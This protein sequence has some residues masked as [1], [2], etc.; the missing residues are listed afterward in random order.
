[1]HHVIA[2]AS[3]GELIAAMPAGQLIAAAAPAG[4]LTPGAVAW[5]AVGA[6]GAILLLYL[7]EL[8]A[9]LALQRTIAL[10]ISAEV[11]AVLSVVE[12]RGYAGNFREQIAKGERGEEMYL[13]PLAISRDYFPVT[14]K[15][16]EKIGTLPRHLAHA[17]VTYYVWAN[18]FIEDATMD[19]GNGGRF[20]AADLV[21]VKDALRVLEKAEAAGE[22]VIGLVR[23]YY[24]TD[25][26]AWKRVQAGMRRARSEL[27]A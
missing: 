9:R 1:M 17:V 3:A 6:L 14:G 8:I 20:P 25:A 18:A 19:R 7:K 27:I 12:M 26:S 10:A 16:A 24:P 13:P 23:G 2:S 11:T 21:Q 5:A 4:G 22:I 15:A